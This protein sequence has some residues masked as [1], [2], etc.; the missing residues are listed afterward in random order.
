MVLKLPWAEKRMLWPFQKSIFQFFVSFW[1][2]NLKLFSGKVKQSV[3]N[4]L[5]RNL[6]I[7]SSLENGFEAT[8]SSK[9][10]V[11]SIWKRHFS[12]F[13]KFLG[14]EVGAIFWESK[15]KPTKLFRSK[16]GHKELLRKWFWGYLELK[17]ECCECL[18]RAF[19]SFLNIF[20]WR[21]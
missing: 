9:T 3:Q 11:M 18:K 21:S 6:V 13:C 14:D 5:D 4:Y 8:L 12:V 7:R 19:F 15:A 2:T 1:V 10:N 20:K 16:L 17:K